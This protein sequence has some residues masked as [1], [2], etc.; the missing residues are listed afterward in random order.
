M[1]RVT[2]CRIG[3]V[4]ALGL[5]VAG[6][7]SKQAIDKRIWA[8]VSA[9]Q[10]FFFEGGQNTLQLHFSMTNNSTEMM[11]PPI[12]SSYLVVNGVE[13]PESEVLIQSGPRDQLWKKLPAHCCVFFS[14]SFSSDLLGK[15]GRHT[16]VW[17]GDGFETSPVQITV[18]PHPQP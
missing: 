13:W 4:L 12:E 14:R 11:D 10:L 3:V 2:I 6:C 1:R 5:C 18:R 7:L 8:K 9:S 15:V 16:I 17:K